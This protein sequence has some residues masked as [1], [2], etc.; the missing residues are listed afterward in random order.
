[1]YIKEAA[2]RYE[3]S[4]A[5]LH[6]LV[7]LGRLQTFKDPR[8]ERATLLRVQDLETL[9][10][11]PQEEVEDMG[12]RTGATADERSAGRLTPELCARMDAMRERI[13]KG[14]TFPDSAEI[15]RKERD[16]RTLQIEQAAH[17]VGRTPGG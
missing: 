17:G 2:A 7:K 15:I 13:S 10:R 16:K 3:V 14:R 6:R 1:M 4:R 8:D 5:K 12:F 11:F 9:F